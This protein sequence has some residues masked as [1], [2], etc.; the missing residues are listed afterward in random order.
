MY[1][2]S[3]HDFLEYVS[4]KSASAQFAENVSLRRETIPTTLL[5]FDRATSHA[6]TSVLVCASPSPPVPSGFCVNDRPVSLANS[7]LCLTNAILSALLRAQG[8]QQN[9]PADWIDGGVIGGVPSTFNRQPALLMN[10]VWASL[11]GQVQTIFPV[12][13]YPSFSC[14]SSAVHPIDWDSFS[15]LRFFLLL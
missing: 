13:C 3:F 7:R 8:L 11:D 4:S 14:I 15:L 12:A 1:W 6:V 2:K 9:P 10:D 5:H